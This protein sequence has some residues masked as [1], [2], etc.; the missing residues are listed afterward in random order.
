MASALFRVALIAPFHFLYPEY[1]HQLSAIGFSNRA[2]SCKAANNA[3]LM[4]VWDFHV[5]YGDNGLS[6]L[7]QIDL[8]TR[9][10]FDLEV[11]V[12]QCNLRSP[13][14]A[15]PDRGGELVRRDFGAPEEP[16]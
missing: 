4:G 5:A 13:V 1:F 11:V 6:A 2:R 12:G 10:I 14:S 8:S 9:H 15:R 7:V 16:G 3:S